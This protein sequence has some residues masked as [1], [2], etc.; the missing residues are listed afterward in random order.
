MTVDEKI[1]RLENEID[2]L[3]LQIAALR[4][5]CSGGNGIVPSRPQGWVPSCNCGHCHN[6]RFYY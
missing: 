1:N 4:Q 6:D 2:D 3:R 5:N